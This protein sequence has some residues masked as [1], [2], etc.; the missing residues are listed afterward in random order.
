MKYRKFFI[1]IAAVFSLA[2]CLTTKTDVPNPE[3]LTKS[4]HP[5]KDIG[6]TITS[7]DFYTMCSRDVELANF[8]ETPCGIYMQ[9]AITTY[10]DALYVALI[11][12][13]SDDENLKTSN[14][15]KELVFRRSGCTD[16]TGAKNDDT[17]LKKLINTKDV[18]KAILSKMA[19][20]NKNNMPYTNDNNGRMNFL[21]WQ[22]LFTCGTWRDFSIETF[23]SP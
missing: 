13:L 3:N 21:V 23:K 7:A 20:T 19:E 4:Q 1:L 9:G 17:A 10:L 14:N 12:F 22:Y 6:F 2:S 18:T 15:A 16:A 8:P 5:Y 11:M